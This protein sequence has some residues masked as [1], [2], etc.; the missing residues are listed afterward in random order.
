MLSR[1]LALAVLLAV[2][3]VGSEAKAERRV[4]LVIGNAEYAHA[5]P[6]R[7]TQNDANDMA[8]A[9]KKLGFDVLLGLD[10]DQRGLAQSVERFARMLDGADVAMFYYAGHAI[11]INDRNFLVSVGAQLTSEFLVPSETIELDAIV[12]LMES[13]S[14]VNLV[15]LDACRNNP[16]AD[17]LRR[18]LASLK[19]S[20]ALGRGLARIEP[21]SRD[22]L[23]AFAAAA[24]WRP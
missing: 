23:V 13:K 6:L 9:L 24:I 12:R 11:Q 15:F 8:D 17:D 10:L 20:V 21:T 4:A 1:L 2:A 16:L 5:P 3:L 19:R 22:T 18:S 14:R 7:N